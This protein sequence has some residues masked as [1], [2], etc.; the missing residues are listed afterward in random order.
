MQQVGSIYLLVL[1]VDVVCGP[2]LTLILVSPK[3]SR[4]ER[5]L[6]LILV[7]LIQF[8]A[9][10]YGIHSVWAARPVALVFE[11][12]RLVLVTANEVAP[13]VLAR[14]PVGLRELPCTGDL[15]LVGT[16][17]PK[18]GAEMLRSVIQGLAGISVAQQPDWWLPWGDVL[19]V[20]RKRIK[21]LSELIAKRPQDAST[22]EAAVLRSGLGVQELSYL[23][24]VSSKTLEWVAL[25]DADLKMVGY[26]PVDGF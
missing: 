18:D 13:T 19:P 6:D 2:L 8:V 24:L 25:L 11:V 12:D 9:L 14:G 21:P 16:R 3:K 22:L 26:A 23:P 5:W 1:A 10:G 20:I 15:L 17:L 7:G 4:R